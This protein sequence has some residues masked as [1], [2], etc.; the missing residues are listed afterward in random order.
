MERTYPVSSK[1]SAE[2]MNEF[3]KDEDYRKKCEDVFID[4][5]RITEVYVNYEEKIEDYEKL[6][7]AIKEDTLSLSYEDLHPYEY[8]GNDNIYSVR[9]QYVPEKRDEKKIT[10]SALE[11]VYI[12]ITPKYEKTVEWLKEKGYSKF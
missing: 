9:I 7:D 6:V 1:K 10:S 4:S 8:N 2:I 12:N 3:Y 11:Q 5:S